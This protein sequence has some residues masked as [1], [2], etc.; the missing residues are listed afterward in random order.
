[1]SCTGVLCGPRS[2]NDICQGGKGSGA[3]RFQPVWGKKIPEEEQDIGPRHELVQEG[4]DP[5][6]LPLVLT[7][8]DLQGDLLTLGPHALKHFC[9]IHI[10]SSFLSGI[11]LRRRMQVQISILI[12]NGTNLDTKT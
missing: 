3:G 8:G 6:E 10:W 12:R 11:L 4:L 7:Q 1:M 2:Q 5:V 9:C